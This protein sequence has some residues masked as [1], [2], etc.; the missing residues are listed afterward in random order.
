MKSKSILTILFLTA[1][2]ACNGGGSR[3]TVAGQCPAGTYEPVPKKV[4]AHQ[5]T[6]SLKADDGA[7]PAGEYSYEGA[8]MFFDG[9]NGLRMQIH[10]VRQRDGKFK[11]HVACV[12][13]AQRPL[14]AFSMTGIRSL[15]VDKNDPKKITAEV[16][17]YTVHLDGKFVT[18]S[19]SD[20]KKK[21]QNPKDAYANMQDSFLVSTDKNTVNYEIRS[22]T[23]DAHGEY[24]L[25]INLRRAD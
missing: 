7:L 10:D 9:K 21:L 24:F 8:I 2:A 19:E 4:G 18:K 25:K 6:V 17:D 5:K 23:S 3:R 13:N 20:P 1:L 11:S 14:N 22:W 16:T 15:K 12:R